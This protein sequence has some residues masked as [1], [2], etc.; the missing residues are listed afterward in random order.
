V[1]PIAPMLAVPMSKADII[2]W[3]DWVMEEKFD[4][5]RLVVTID[6][7]G[8]VTA[9]TRQRKH[10]SGDKDQ[11]DVT[12]MLPK[13][14]RDHLS[15]GFAPSGLFTV[16][17]GELLVR[18]PD[19][20]VGTSTDV[21][22]TDLKEHLFFTVFDV[23]MTSAGS[24]M[25]HPWAL[26]RSILKNLFNTVGGGKQVTDVGSVHL[27]D[28][29]ECC[30]ADE[31]AS[32]CREVWERGGEGLIL[33]DKRARYEQGKRR[34]SFVKLK[35]LF[36]AVCKITGFEASRGNVLNRGPFATVV[37]EVVTPASEHPQ[38]LGH[39]TSVKTLD[40]AELEKFNAAAHAVVSMKRAH[41][42]LGRLLRIEYQ[43][44][45]ADGGLR[46][47]RWDRWEDE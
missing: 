39:C 14:L 10:A 13:H 11:R 34:A 33:K 31:V 27:A 47:P 46:H 42:A 21:P 17:D 8:N 24:C 16:L 37:L 41:P 35:K 45:A 26:R 36:T 44:I 2:D 23:L 6:S 3:N 20:R 30:D 28:T 29:F 19:G 40:D 1:K 7:L 43:D 5:W 12:D 22:R 25:M 32:Y 15:S 9:H 4:G 38:T 18:L